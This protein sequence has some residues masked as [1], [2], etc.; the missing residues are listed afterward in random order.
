MRS[1]SLQQFL[2]FLYGVL[3]ISLSPAAAIAQPSNPDLDPAHFRT[4]LV[5]VYNRVLVHDA[6]REERLS[7]DPR[8]W[9]WDRPDPSYGQA[10]IEEGPWV[11]VR[12]SVIAGLGMRESDDCDVPCAT[13]DFGPGNRWSGSQA[14]QE[15]R[16]VWVYFTTSRPG[17][18]PGLW[19]TRV[20]ANRSDLMRS[21][22]EVTAEWRDGSWIVSNFRVIE[23]ILV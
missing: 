23:R 18:E 20:Y 8:A 2:G 17:P 13:L 4:L 5:T 15:T 19:V 21:T 16:L 9:K 3:I 7:V 11:D 10:F 6:G 12:R 14:C 22:I 1:P